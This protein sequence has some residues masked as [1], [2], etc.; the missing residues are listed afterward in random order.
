M[1]I[2]AYF[3]PF[4][5]GLCDIFRYFFRIFKEVFWRVCYARNNGRGD[6][7]GR[8]CQYRAAKKTSRRSP[9][10]KNFHSLEVRGSR[11][12][13]K[14]SR[15]VGLA[16]GR[17]SQDGGFGESAGSSGSSGKGN[18]VEIVRFLLA[19]K[20]FPLGEKSICG[21][22]SLPLLG[23]LVLGLRRL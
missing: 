21:R 8:A 12:D 7:D 13:S 11:A 15:R 17:F 19:W 3:Q 5:K 14:R 2:I 18:L 6:R 10:G 9:D 22:G 4:N 23:V 1:C 16:T 20:D